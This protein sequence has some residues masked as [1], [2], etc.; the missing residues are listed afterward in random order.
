MAS[1][2]EVLKQ[3]ITELE[4]KN[5]KLEAENAELKKEN[6]EIPNLRNKLLVFDAKIAELKRRN[7]KALRANKE[8][9]ERCD[10]KV[11]KLEARLV[12]VEQNDK[13]VIPEVLPEIS[14]P[15]NNTDNKSSENKK[16]DFFLDEVHKKK[17]SNEIRQRNRKKKLLRE[18]S[19]KDLSEDVSLLNK[20]PTSS[21]TQ[22]KES[23]SHKKKLEAENIVQDVFDFTMNGSEKKQLEAELS[24]SNVLQNI[25][26]LYENACTAENEKVKANQN[27]NTELPDDQEGSNIDSEEKILDDQTDASEMVSAESPLSNHK[28]ESLWNDIKGEWGAGD[29]Y[30]NFVISYVE[31]SFN[32]NEDDDNDGRG[33]CQNKSGPMGTIKSYDMT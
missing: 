25:N 24:S 14:A 9:N 22:N 17:V 19:T 16:T 3:C 26:H 32:N 15:N 11:K 29:Y 8:N 27:P 28:E 18:S 13:E 5:A 23:R 20:P 1:E 4:A 12:I 7:A 10:V 33:Y 30:E 21:V 31:D 6:T 2:L